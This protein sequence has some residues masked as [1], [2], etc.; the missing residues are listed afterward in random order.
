M[1]ATMWTT[2]KEP[3]QEIKNRGHEEKH[4]NFILVVRR[5]EMLTATKEKMSGSKK[6]KA[7]RNTYDISSVKR[8]IRKFH[9]AVVQNNS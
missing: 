3:E 4:D 6:K 7:D 9:V 8:V 5:K 2:E 1:S